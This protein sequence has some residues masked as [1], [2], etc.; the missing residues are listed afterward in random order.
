MNDSP[1]LLHRHVL[2]T[3][4]NLWTFHELLRLLAVLHAQLQIQ[5]S[6]VF[7]IHIFKPPVSLQNQLALLECQKTF[8]I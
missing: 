6:T 2:D 1:R 5:V 7:K 4:I 3:T 8:P